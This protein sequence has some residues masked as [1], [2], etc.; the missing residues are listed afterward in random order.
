LLVLAGAAYRWCHLPTPD[1]QACSGNGGPH[2]LL[3]IKQ[4]RDGDIVIR[5][6][7]DSMGVAF[8]Q[9][10]QYVLPFLCESFG[11]GSALFVL[12]GRTPARYAEV[13]YLRLS[14]TAR[15][16]VKN[17]TRD[18]LNNLLHPASLLLS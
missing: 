18:R 8:P 2:C 3:L 9:P 10:H 17:G 6:K 7:D 13:E 14:R 4:Q 16:T 11:D 5:S 15:G 1:P 12:Y